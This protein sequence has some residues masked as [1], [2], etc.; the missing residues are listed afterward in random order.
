MDYLKNHQP[1][2]NK[3]ELNE[4]VS[5]HLFRCNFELNKTDRSVI[6][7]LSRYAVKYP[8][9][10]HLKLDTLSKAIKKATRTI[11]RSIRKLEELNI[12]ERKSF[13]REVSGGYGANLYVFLPPNV[14]SELSPRQE[15]TSPTAPTK[16]HPKSEN[17]AIN[18]KSKK[19]LYSHNTYKQVTV[20]HYQRFK[21]LLNSYTGEENQQQINRLY[22]I[23]R[24][25]TC[26][27]LKFS[28]HQDKKELFE[29]LS[30]QAITIAFQSTKKKNIRNLFGYYDGILRELIEK[31][32]F[33][34]AFIDYSVSTVLIMLNCLADNSKF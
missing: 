1:F 20:T 29:A 21:G 7:M 25:Q 10:A 30:L 32:L 26:R 34:D 22:G 18:L 28:I 9:V 23:Y 14:I 5:S 27:L 17:E 33:S 24:G 11:Q 19:V 8:G 12:I 4:A 31:T 16:E 13:T 3:R 2:S 15:P 6:E